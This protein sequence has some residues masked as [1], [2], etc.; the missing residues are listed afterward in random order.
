MNT[1][2]FSIL[3]LIWGTT[4]L[5]IKV[6][7]DDLP[8]FLSASLRF[9][10]ASSVL[11]L[12]KRNRWFR[13]EEGS[14]DQHLFYFM[15]SFLW[16]T[17]PYGLVYWGEQY[18][19]SG[20]S[21]IIFATM[22][23]YVAVMGHFW[24]TGETL[25]VRKVLGLL[26]GFSGLLVIFFDTTGEP[27]VYALY[28]LVALAL[29][30]LTAAISNV[31]V[32]RRITHIDP[33]SMNAYVMVYGAV[34]LM[35]SSLFLEWDQP[36]RF[37]GMAIF[38]LFYLGI[39]GSALAFV[40]Y[41]YLLKTETALKMSLIVYITPVIALFVGWLFREETVTVMVVVGSVLVFLGI[42]LVSRRDPVKSGPG[43]SD[44]SG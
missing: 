10:I 27:T 30:P 26:V 42:Y 38:T 16:I 37:S 44:D 4:W 12:V 43:K 20:L 25:T 22:P 33:V 35:A 13:G 41:V 31:L 3:C 21:A 5:A 23:F 2:L 11:F 24:I 32:K 7:L 6:G 18:V 40:L 19:S 36:Y 34:F 28:G 14:K 8:P 29:S 9:V 17:L 39:M 15:I 1:F